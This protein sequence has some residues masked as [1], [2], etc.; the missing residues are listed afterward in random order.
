MSDQTNTAAPTV[1]VIP[2]SGEVAY[3][4][5]M[6]DIN[7]ELTFPA[8]TEIE[9]KYVGESPEEKAARASRYRADFEEYAKRSKAES[10]TARAGLRTYAHGMLGYIEHVWQGKE[11]FD[12]EH[13]AS[14]IS[15]L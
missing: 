14:Q 6:Q 10:D 7:P 2:A 8:I 5:V 1:P 11:Q 9:Q 15:Q 13:I 12:L 4:F 3:N